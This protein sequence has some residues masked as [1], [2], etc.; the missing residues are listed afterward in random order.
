I[1]FNALADGTPYLVLEYLAGES[2]GARLTR[3]PLPVDTALDLLRQM[4]SALLAAH[5]AG[6]VHRDMKPENVFLCPSDAGGVIHDRVKVL[7]FGISKL[8]GSQQVMQHESRR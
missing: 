2:L 8:R 1:D 4:G 3:R 5:R 6:V 7:D